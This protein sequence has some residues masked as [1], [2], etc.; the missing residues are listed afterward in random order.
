MYDLNTIYNFIGF[1]GPFILYL[2]IFFLLIHKK[3]F[4]LFY[5]LGFIINILLNHALKGIFKFPRPSQDTPLFK[6]EMANSQK[7]G[8]QKYGMPSGHSQEIGFTIGFMFFILKSKLPWFI[9]LLIGFITCSQRI[10]NKNHY[11]DQ[12]L[13]GFVVGLCIGFLFYYLTLHVLSGNMKMKMDDNAP[14]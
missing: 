3:S 11:L 2:Y 13:I 7:F 5:S 8:F 12:I 9:I 14:I 10:F 4:L 1:T 6:L